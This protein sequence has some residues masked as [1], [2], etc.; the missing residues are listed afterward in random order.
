MKRYPSDIAFTSSVKALQSENGSRESYARMEQGS[1]WKTKVD[2]ELA[3]FLLSLDMFYLGTSNA[4]N[5]PYIQ[6][7][8][9]PPGFL[10][11][12]DSSTLAFA[13]FSGN[14]QYITLGNITDNP[15][16][17]IFL[18]D[19]IN[20]R[21]V[22]LWGRAKFVEDDPELMK[23]LSHEDYPAQVERAIVFEIDTWD[24]NCPQ[25]I[26]QRIPLSAA[27]A[28]I[29]RLQNRIAELEEQSS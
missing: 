29:Q 17:F 23:Q 6:Y 2:D 7:R 12:I 1:G 26:H 22:K 15:K 24:R 19:Y 28:E 3:D 13:D 20:R 21:R 18:M 10:K 16:A 8:G 25:H 5:Q 11:V 27:S 4:A 9:G 14:R